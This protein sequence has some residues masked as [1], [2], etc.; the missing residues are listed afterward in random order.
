MVFKMAKGFE[1]MLKQLKTNT[2]GTRAAPNTQGT[3]L[4]DTDFLQQQQSAQSA[5]GHAQ[6]QHGYQDSMQHPPQPEF[7]VSYGEQAFNMSTAVGT[8]GISPDTTGSAL[9]WGFQD[10]DLWQVGMGWDLL[11]LSGMGPA[12]VDFNSS[13][14][15]TTWY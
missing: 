10:D 15:G 14:T 11:D 3:S 8:T 1:R 7:G 9:N 4:H 6:T 2:R 5:M 12:S 13:G